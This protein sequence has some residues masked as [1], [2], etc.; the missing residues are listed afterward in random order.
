MKNKRLLT[1]LCDKTTS[2]GKFSETNNINNHILVFAVKPLRNKPELFQAFARVSLTLRKGLKTFNDKV[3]LGL[4][5]CK[6]YDQHH[7]KR[8][9][10]CQ[11][12]GHF[13]K[14]CPDLNT[15]VCCK[16]SLDHK[17]SECH[18]THMKCSNCSKAG[19]PLIECDHK[20]DDSKCPTLLRAQEKMKDNM[21]K[22]L[23]S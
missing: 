18:S 7:I 17:T 21:V 22:H 5:T 2:S 6:I 3:L 4:L 12:F 8:C 16:C 10:N 9:N 20:A 13:Y 23:N 1:H 15:P 19:I 11:S 14:K